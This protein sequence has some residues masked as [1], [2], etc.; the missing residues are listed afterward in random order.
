M[1]VGFLDYVISITNKCNLS[2]RYCYEKKLNTTLGNIDEKT[3]EDIIKFIS[4]R[5][6][7]KYIYLFGGEPLLYKD[8]IKKFVTSLRAHMFI[9]TTNGMLLDEEFIKWSMENNVRINLSHDGEDCSDRGIDVN[10]LNSRLAILLRYQPKTLVQLVYTEKTLDKL[11]DNII[12]LKKLG[13]IRFSLAMDSGLTPEDPDSFSDKLREQWKK[14]SDIDDIIVLELRD[15]K[16]LVK[17]GENSK[18]EICKKKMYINW[19]GKIYPCVQFQNLSDFLCGDVVNGLDTART[20]EAYP[21]YPS[22]STRCTD[23][24][25]ARYCRNSCACIKM[26]TT[27]TLT[28][29]SEASCLLEQVLILTVLEKIQTEKI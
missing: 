21:E 13:V 26:S 22:L 1:E 3:S 28:D 14:I 2:C 10:E 25:I 29:I 8:L 9:V 15:K 20:E 12:Y 5:N 23:C 17:T 6:D 19:D 24:E 4:S 27:G 11:Y 7:A 18:C 16:K